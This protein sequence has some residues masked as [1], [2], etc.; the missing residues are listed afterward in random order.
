MLYGCIIIIKYALA[1]VMLTGTLTWDD[2]IVIIMFPRPASL[3]AWYYFVVTIQILI[4]TVFIIDNIRTKTSVSLY[5]TKSLR[6][7]YYWVCFNVEWNAV[8]SISVNTIY[9]IVTITMLTIRVEF[10]DHFHLI[11]EK[12]KKYGNFFFNTK[13]NQR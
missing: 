10:Y 5:R 4:D 12:C 8:F 2:K 9:I 7:Y 13:I 6:I 11:L 3:T 1:V